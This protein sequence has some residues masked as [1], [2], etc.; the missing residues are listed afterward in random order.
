MFLERKVVMPN[1]AINVNTESKTLNVSV[2]GVGVPNIDSVCVYQYR[3]SDGNPS[4]VDVS[5]NARTEE[6]NGVIKEVSYY[7]Y[8]SKMADE[9]MA[10]VA[11]KHDDV[12]GFV[13]VDSVTADIT[14]FM[15]NRKRGF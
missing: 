8:G 3:D 1:V 6:N 11:N 5:M 13:G 14:E 9:V 4:L 7:V 15:S 12:P 10:A 2:D